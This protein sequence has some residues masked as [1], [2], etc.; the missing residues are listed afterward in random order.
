MRSLVF[1]LA[2]VAVTVSAHDRPN[3][4]DKVSR[5]MELLDDQTK[6]YFCDLCTDVVEASEEYIGAEGDA[7]LDNVI[8]ECVSAISKGTPIGFAQFICDTLFGDNVRPIIKQLNDP[9]FRS[10]NAA[11]VCGQITACPSTYSQ[12]SA[13]KPE[14]PAFFKSLV[15]LKAK[16]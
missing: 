12:N 16:P 3:P 1:V 11:K 8:N 15:D 5:K 13:K 7:G 9:D 6:K 2:L 14:L 10:A 4:F